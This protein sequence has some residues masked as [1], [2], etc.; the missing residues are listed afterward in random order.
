MLNI[1]FNKVF[2]SNHSIDPLNLDFAFNVA[3]RLDEHRELVE[4]LLVN[5]FYL[6][7]PENM[8]GELLILQPRMTI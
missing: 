2:K 6:S 8:T 4:D 1:L 5:S 3:K 7:K